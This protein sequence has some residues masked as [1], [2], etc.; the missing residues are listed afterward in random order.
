VSRLARQVSGVRPALDSRRRRIVVVRGRSAIGT[1]T[2]R[3]EISACSVKNARETSWQKAPASPS[4]FWART[5]SPVSSAKREFTLCCGGSIGSPG[6]DCGIAGCDGCGHPPVVVQTR[7]YRCADLMERTEHAAALDAAPMRSRCHRHFIVS[8]GAVGP[9]IRTVSYLVPARRGRHGRGVPRL[10]Q[11]ASPEGR[12]FAENLGVP[13]CSQRRHQAAGLIRK[14][15][16]T[17]CTS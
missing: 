8:R 4:P 13:C 1:M 7:V 5:S 9:G 16:P 10:R 6:E 14:R 12:H 3:F 11:Q 17:V 2:S 15:P